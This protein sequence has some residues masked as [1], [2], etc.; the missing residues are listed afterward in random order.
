MTSKRSIF[1]L[2]S[3]RYFQARPTKN[4][5]PPPYQ[6]KTKFNYEYTE[7]LKNYELAVSD[8][9]DNWEKHNALYR[10]Y[11]EG[12]YFVT[13]SIPDFE[14][15]FGGYYGEYWPSHFGGGYHKFLKR[16][17]TET[18]QYNHKYPWIN[19]IRK[20]L[21]E[22]GIHWDFPRGQ[23]YQIV[24]RWLLSMYMIIFV[25]KQYSNWS[26]HRANNKSLAADPEYPLRFNLPFYVYIIHQQQAPNFE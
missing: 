8:A 24:M 12:E 10:H 4:P 22:R 25:G 13:H 6:I 1:Q 19:F 15:F 5:L 2:V 18:G 26:S 14:K 7:P 17:M 3:K 23:D 16:R 11:Q 21:D 20:K 9:G